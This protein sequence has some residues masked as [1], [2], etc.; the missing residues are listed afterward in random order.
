MAFLPGWEFPLFG[1]WIPMVM[2]IQMLMKIDMT[3]MQSGRSADSRRNQQDGICIDWG[4][5]GWRRTGQGEQ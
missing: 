2:D 1:Q 3:G 5:P 4:E